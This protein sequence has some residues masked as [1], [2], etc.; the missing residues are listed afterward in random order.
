MHEQ[1]WGE[2]NPTLKHV[3]PP[4][5]LP[6]FPCRLLSLL[7]KQV[8]AQEQLSALPPPRELVA[9]QQELAARISGLESD[10]QLL[11]VD[12]K[13]SA[14]KAKGAGKEIAA[15]QKVRRGRRGG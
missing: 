9:A 14:E 15:L 10:L 2:L 5:T 8:A 1:Q 13:S 3:T 7:Q 12:Q 6:C 4:D 11:Q